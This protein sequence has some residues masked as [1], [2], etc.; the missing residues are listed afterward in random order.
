M[1]AVPQRRATS[2]NSLN[3]R[4][5]TISAARSIRRAL[6]DRRLTPSLSV[7][8]VLP[9]SSGGAGRQGQPK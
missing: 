2:S 8:L 9:Q 6:F 3:I 5:T 4:L 7:T 1:A